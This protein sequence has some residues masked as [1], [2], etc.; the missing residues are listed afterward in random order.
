MI[1]SKSN[2][3]GV[4][5]VI[6]SLQQNWYSKLLTKWLGTANYECYPRA[7]KLISEDGE[8]NELILPELSTDQTESI[9]VLFNDNHAVTSF[10]LDSD[11]GTLDDKTDQITQSVSIIFQVQLNK[12]Y[13]S[14][15]RLD[16]R[17]NTDVLNVL[18][19]QVQYKY[20]SIEIEKGIRKVYDD[21]TFSKE[22]KDKIKFND[23][24]NK[25]VVKFT[26]DVVYGCCNC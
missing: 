19:K 15:E 24:G 21:L 25:H 4:D 18:K 2:K 13:T 9:E 10:F 11:S 14:A 8:G 6:E 22:F 16:E 1:V 12:V 23:I 17:F 20:G 3:Y 26:F 5:V 7:N